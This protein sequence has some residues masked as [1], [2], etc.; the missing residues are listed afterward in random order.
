M[1]RTC[2]GAG[3]ELHGRIV[4]LGAPQLHR[5]GS[6][7]QSMGCVAS[8]AEKKAASLCPG[9]LAAAKDWR[10]HVLDCPA[11]DREQSLVARG[12]DA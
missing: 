8:L 5:A 9:E 4:G 6:R 1:L 12:S 3:A 11:G 2:S 10:F 7:H